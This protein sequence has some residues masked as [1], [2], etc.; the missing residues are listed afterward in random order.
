VFFKLIYLCNHV[1]IFG[2]PLVI[3]I[4]L[5]IWTAFPDNRFHMIMSISHEHFFIEWLLKQQSLPNVGAEGEILWDFMANM[6][7]YTKQ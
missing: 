2:N 7:L 1:Q 3:W 4:R 6:D 5:K